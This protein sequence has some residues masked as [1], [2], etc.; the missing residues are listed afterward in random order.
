[1]YIASW[2]AT[3]VSGFYL[4]LGYADAVIERV[5][6]VHFP[7]KVNQGFSI[8]T[9]KVSLRSSTIARLF[10]A[11]IHGFS[12]LSCRRPLFPCK[13]A[14]RSFSASSGAFFIRNKMPVLVSGKRFLPS[15]Y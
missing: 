8:S 13:R 1:M 12:F 7:L 9:S 4:S 6:H 2:L 3:I 5:H 11:R 15:A 10:A 14:D